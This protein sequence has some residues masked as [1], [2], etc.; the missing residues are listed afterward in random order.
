MS[1]VPTDK[2]SSFNIPTLDVVKPVGLKATACRVGDKEREKSQMKAKNKAD[3][4]TGP[5]CSLVGSLSWTQSVVTQAAVQDWRFPD[6][7]VPN[8]E[9]RKCNLPKLLESSPL[10]HW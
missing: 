4:Q 5:K 3:S 9:I 10:V 6:L 7:S 8:R 1:S 2:G